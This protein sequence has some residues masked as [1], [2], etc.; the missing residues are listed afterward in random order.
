MTNCSLSECCITGMLSVNV[1]KRWLMSFNSLLL[2]SIILL[3]YR[4]LIIDQKLRGTFVD[5]VLTK[6]FGGQGQHVLWLTYDW[7]QLLYEDIT[8]L[9]LHLSSILRLMLLKRSHS[10]GYNLLVLYRITRLLLLLLSSRW[11]YCSINIDG[12]CRRRSWPLPFRCYLLR[13]ILAYLT[14]VV[15]RRTRVDVVH[16]LL[17]CWLGHDQSILLYFSQLDRLTWY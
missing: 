5:I 16:R 6:S 1:C 7:L 10:L 9:L 14:Q 8:L 17:L 13:N 12:Y 11:G 4:S 15:L 3:R 2:F